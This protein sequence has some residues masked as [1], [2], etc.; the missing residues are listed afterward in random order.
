MTSTVKDYMSSSEFCAWM[1]EHGWTVAGLA[2]AGVAGKRSSI[3][4]LRSGE[5]PVPKV[6][7]LALA[8]LNHR[9][10]RKER[11]R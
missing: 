2:A 10:P 5:L 7:A 9:T 4:R 8:P 11:S 3:F 1:D 6:L